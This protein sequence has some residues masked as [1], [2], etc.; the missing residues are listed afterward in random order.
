MSKTRQAFGTW[1]STI[2]AELITQA[3]PRLS[4]IQSYDDNL[5]WV[6]GRP[7][8]AG[9]NVIMCRD[10]TGTIRDLLPS[11]FSHYSK[12]HEYGGMAYTVHGDQLYFVNAADQR[13]YPV[14]SARTRPPHSAD[15]RGP[16][17][18]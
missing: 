2:S 7:W 1:P 10:S 8:D 9:R 16:S 6:E 12:V 13:I 5:Y 15:T 11:P 18:R 4:F 14:K 3:A 17:L